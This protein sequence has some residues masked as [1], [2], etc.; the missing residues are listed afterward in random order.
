MSLRLKATVGIAVFFVVCLLAMNFLLYEVTLKGFW[1]SEADYAAQTVDRLRSALDYEYAIH[2]LHAGLLGYREDIYE[3]MGTRDVSAIKEIAGSEVFTSRSTAFLMFLDLQG[4]VLFETMQDN[5]KQKHA[6]TLGEKSSLIHLVPYLEQLTRDGEA[7]GLYFLG[8]ENYIIG[9]SRIFPSAS[10][11]SRGYCI[12]GT[13]AEELIPNIKSIL[14]YPLAFFSTSRIRDYLP[15]VQK[16][17]IKSLSAEHTFVIDYGTSL[18]K[19]WVPQKDILGRR[20]TVVLFDQERFI[21]S[22]GKTAISNSYG[23]LVLMGLALLFLVLLVLQRILFGRM[24]LLH[25]AAL[26]ISENAI[27]GIRLLLPSSAGNKDELTALERAL[28]ASVSAMEDVFDNM[29]FPI[30]MTETSG[31]IVAANRQTSTLLDIELEVLKRKNVRDVVS[32]S[33]EGDV[34]VFE[35]YFFGTVLKAGDGGAI[36]VEVHMEFFR[37]GNRQLYLFMA[38]DLRQRRAAEDA[39]RAKSEF[40]ANMSHEI[41]TPMNAIIGMSELLMLSSLGRNEELCALNI[42]NAAKSLLSIIND[43]LDF[44][45]IEA[46]KLELTELDY[47]FLSLINDVTSIVFMRASEKGILLLVDLDPEIPQIMAGDEIR[48][49]QILLNILSNAVKFTTE[50]EVRLTV[51]YVPAEGDGGSLQVEISDT[52]LGIRPEDMPNLFSAFTRLDSKRTR[53][54]EGTGLGLVIT[55]RLVDLMNGTLDVESKYG[56][57]TTFRIVLPQISRGSEKIAAVHDSG[58]KS[59]LLYSTIPA[60]RVLLT[61]ILE[62]LHVAYVQCESVAQFSRY[63]SNNSADAPSFTH[64]IFA[65]NASEQLD[66]FMALGDRPG[67]RIFLLTSMSVA[68]LN[69]IPAGKVAVFRPATVISVANILNDEIDLKNRGSADRSSESVIFKTREVKILVVDDNQVNLDVAAGLLKHYHIAVDQSLSGKEALRRVAQENY[70]IIFM[71][72]MM[73]GM[74]GVETTRAIRAMGGKYLRMTIIALSANA[75]SGAAELFVT[76]GM[77]DF[78]SKP[79]MLKQL[80]DMLYK[81]LPPDKIVR[82]QARTVEYFP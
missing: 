39:N 62:K 72:H 82:T 21:Y 41:R 33:W 79:I 44:S 71:D 1:E 77:N 28:N 3:Y 17:L 55:R 74:D 24:A 35:E 52:G 22:H 73:P 45:K 37:Y 10:H 64:A 68:V 69:A 36:P 6:M 34:P 80:S 27:S 60:E 48:L 25:K 56:V 38:Q 8:D 57:G 78:L 20:N 47:E 5:E 81:W 14:Q 30:I 51:R 32:L 16:W 26:R 2:R 13:R 75:V 67:C 12:L 46:N 49:K 53:A 18:L 70:D 40:L 63:Y 31:V 50:G 76:S 11:P 23:V 15:P 4:N 54:T 42:R 19:I 65:I 7:A 43:I 61:H 9:I 58:S 29:P 59:V 66:V